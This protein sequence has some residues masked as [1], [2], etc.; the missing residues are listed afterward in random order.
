[1]YKGQSME[2]YINT[3]D[4]CKVI[5]FIALHHIEIIVFNPSIYS[6][7]IIKNFWCSKYHTGYCGGKVVSQ[8]TNSSGL[9]FLMLL[10][11]HSQWFTFSWLFW[12]QGLASTVFSPSFDSISH[13]TPFFSNGLGCRMESPT[14]NLQVLGFL[15]I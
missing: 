1:M 3:F 12:L 14:R 2:N 15:K 5:L 6:A 8:W 10:F 7:N 4:K 9:P 13:G 11:V